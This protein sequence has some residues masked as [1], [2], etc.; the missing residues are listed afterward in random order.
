MLPTTKTAIMM[1]VAH[2]NTSEHAERSDKRI[3]K[4]VAFG[5]QALKNLGRLPSLSGERYALVSPSA[6]YSAMQEAYRLT[7]VADRVSNDTKREFSLPRRAMSMA[8]SRGR[9]TPDMVSSLMSFFREDMESLAHHLR[10]SF[11]PEKISAKEALPILERIASE[12][13]IAPPTAADVSAVIRVANPGSGHAGGRP[14]KVRT[15]TG[16]LSGHSRLYASTAIV[17]PSVPSQTSRMPAVP[18][19][20]F[21]AGESNTAALLDA[22][23]A[24]T[25]RQSV[26]VSV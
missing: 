24:A 7:R 5:Q 10:L 11:L 8:S 4:R 25:L 13:R 6:R 23:H 26:E 21:G 19:P 17:E 14:R 22:F 16:T 9:I 2:T 20:T 1:A 12:R 3:A 18:A 15:F